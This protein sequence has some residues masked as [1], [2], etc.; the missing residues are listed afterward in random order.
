[1]LSLF[2]VFIMAW[3]AFDT[4]GLGSLV[5]KNFV[6]FR[7]DHLRGSHFRYLYD[8]ICICAGEFVRN[9]VLVS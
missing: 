5:S 8:C 4:V 3:H 6:T 1:M 7:G 9:F 2:L